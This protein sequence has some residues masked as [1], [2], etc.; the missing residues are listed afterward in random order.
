MI[1]YSVT[2]SIVKDLESDWLEW[3][4]GKHIPDVM[5]TGY[6]LEYNMFRIMEPVVDERFATYTIQYGTANI[7][8]LQEY[9]RVAAPALQAEHTERYKDQYTAFRTLLEKL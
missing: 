8:N 2:V 5:A 1:I 4:Q 3:M 7:R 6:F 9:Q